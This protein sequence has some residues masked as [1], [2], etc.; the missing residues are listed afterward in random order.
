MASAGPDRR[1]PVRRVGRPG[2]ADGDRVHGGD[3][4]TIRCPARSRAPTSTTI[5]L[6]PNDAPDGTT[7]VDDASGFNDLDAFARDEIERGHLVDDGF[8][9][10]TWRCSSRRRARPAGRWPPLTNDSV[11]VQGIAGLF[12]DADGAGSSLERYVEICARDRSRMPNDIPAEGLGDQ[13][14]G[15]R[16]ETPDGARVH[17]FVWRIGNLLLAISGSGP[18]TLEQVRE[19]ADLVDRR[20]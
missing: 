17:I 12:H 16:G 3:T 20:T 13:S 8:R 14:F 7:Y 10:V 1:T 9:S 19:L 6:G 2:R 18:T 15:L 11:I 4:R 5:V